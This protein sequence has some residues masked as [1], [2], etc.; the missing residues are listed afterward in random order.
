MRLAFYA[1]M[2][3]PEH[4]TPSGD[5]AMARGLM[6][7]LR[8]TGAEVTLASTFR[9]RDGA[10]DAGVQSRLLVEADR[11]VTRLLPQGRA[12]NWRGWI[13]YHN[14]Y[15]APDLIGPAVAQALSIPYLQVESTRAR[16]RLTG[17][18]ARF[19]AKA[20]AAADAAAV[21]FYVTTRDAETLMR[22]APAEQRLIHL[23]PFLDRDALPEPSRGG[24]PMLSVGMM[25][26]G[27]KL[28][29][30]GI[31]AQTLALLKSD[32]HLDIA[33]DGPAMR[34]V[35]ALMAP[36]GARVRFLGA[37]DQTAL[38]TA[39]AGASLLFW[40][41]VN[42]AFGLAYLEAQAA[43]L[44]IVAQDRPGVRDVLAPG[45]YPAPEDGA[46]G[47]A[48]QL[49]PLLTAPEARHTAGQ[50]ARSHVAA[51]HLRPAAAARLTEGLQAAGVTP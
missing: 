18:W 50:A 34:Q 24:G 38:D 29:S 44:P 48:R 1:P 45:P 43:G 36:F 19:A 49:W 27:D 31:I 2:K 46:A 40:P 32:W 37:L 16:K 4:P 39:Y 41:G 8:Q 20:E 7:A 21:V 14:Y 28:A 51:H 3:P 9:S 6:S 15:K 25:R 47:L 5:R 30:Y 22:D 23:P 13:T 10:G 11:E 26:S 17:A 12:E 42:E 35:C 33:G